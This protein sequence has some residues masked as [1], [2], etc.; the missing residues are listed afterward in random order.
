[1]KLTTATILMAAVMACFLIAGAGGQLVPAGESQ[2][3]QANATDS[4]MI[5]LPVPTLAPGADMTGNFTKLDILPSYSQ[6]SLKPGESKEV[7]VTVR[8][9]DTKT[10]ALRPS[11]KSQ[12]YGSP[13]I[14]DSSWITITPATADVPA[15]GSAK[16]TVKA[17]VPSDTL[18]GSYNTMIVFTDEQYPSA[19][20]TPYPSYIHQM[21]LGLNVVSPPVVQIGTPS[22]SDQVESGKEYH[23]SVDIRNTG[24]N[25]IRLNPKIGSDSYPMYG[26][27]GVQE[28][29]LTESDFSLNAPSALQPG[30]TGTMNV[31][32]NVPADASGYYNGYIDLGIDDPALMEGEGRVMLN[33]IVWRQPP[34]PFIRKFTLDTADPI[35]IELS[36]GISYTTPLPAGT[37]SQMP[38][39][40]PTFE[41]L[42]TGPEGNVLIHPV[43]KVIKGTV[44]LGG[45]PTVAIT[46]QTGTYQET[47]V[48]YVVTYTA[49]GKPGAYQLSVMPKNA[50]SFD[51]K[52][53]LGPLET[54]IPSVT[55]LQTTVP[56]SGPAVPVQNTTA[57]PT[58]VAV[59]GTP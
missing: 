37:L 55:T 58:Q 54:L 18:R 13:Y 2:A 59:N 33:F 45:D 44:N 20:P 15:G 12:P 56:V 4:G 48:Q 34:E 38:V 41:T 6:L 14:L 5:P 36:S 26:P 10:V 25:A 16:F 49:Q 52:I 21:S 46:P 42:L 17:S 39:R 43:Q 32:V 23:Y 30:A 47:N 51:Y 11:V 40:E 53:S 3:S 24:N 31:A 57:V 1:M 50:Q 8:N 29:A 27:S 7:T 35:S 19:Y 22:I 9:R 28:P